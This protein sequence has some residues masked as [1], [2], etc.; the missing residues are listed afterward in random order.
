MYKQFF[1]INTITVSMALCFNA[2]A[3]AQFTGDVNQTSSTQ[4]APTYIGDIIVG[5]TDTSGSAASPAGTL[6]VDGGTQVTGNQ[7]LIIGNGTS[8]SGSTTL[9]G[10]GS[11]LDL[12]RD[13]TVGSG[14][15]AYGELNITEGAVVNAAL[16]GS[17]VGRVGNSAGSVGIVN[18][19][20]I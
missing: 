10:P 17:A 12:S 19:T 5:N 7:K 13:I 15:N 11:I 6:V 2:W 1:K 18:I 8:S 20:G 16:F 9:A 14:N 3:D 4:L